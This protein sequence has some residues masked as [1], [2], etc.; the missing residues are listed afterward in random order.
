MNYPYTLRYD[1]FKAA[2]RL[3]LEV[4]PRARFW[5]IVWQRVLPVVSLV[6]L[7]LLLNDIFRHHFSYPPWLGGSLAG[8]SVAGLYSLALRPFVM[9]RAFRK[10]RPDVGADEHSVELELFEGKL[11]SRIP[12][13]SEGRFERN[14]IVNFAESDAIALFYL[15]EKKFL[16]VPKSALPSEGWT[17]LREW[18]G[19]K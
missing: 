19:T 2:Q 14:A 4:S 17:E 10:L 5:F 18:I 9:R 15:G 13:K 1:D 12:G 6:C 3:H 11:I 7:A 8:I 16:F